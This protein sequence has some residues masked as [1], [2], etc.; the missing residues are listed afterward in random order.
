MPCFLKRVSNRILDSN[1]RE[2]DPV[3]VPNSPYF[4]NVAAD[5]TAPEHL[6][7]GGAWIR[8]YARAGD[9]SYILCGRPGY[10]AWSCIRALREREP[11]SAHRQD[12]RSRYHEPEDRSGRWKTRRAGEIPQRQCESYFWLRAKCALGNC[13]HSQA[14]EQNRNTESHRN[15]QKYIVTLLKCIYNLGNYIICWT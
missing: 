11:R 2:G 15:I 1:P 5:L 3:V 6:C 8:R 10:S 4:V 9:E 14:S 12:S 13:F 7:C